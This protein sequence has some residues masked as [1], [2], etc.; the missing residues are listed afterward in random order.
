MEGAAVHLRARGH[1]REQAPRP[2]R[3]GGGRG[4]ARQGCRLPRG[5]A[6]W[7]W[8]GQALQKFAAGWARL[9]PHTRRLP[10]SPAETTK[11]LQ[12]SHSVKVTLDS[13]AARPAEEITAES[14]RQLL[15]AAAATFGAAR[16]SALFANVSPAQPWAHRRPSAS[17]GR[18]APRARTFA[19]SSWRRQPLPPP[20]TTGPPARTCLCE[21]RA[22]GGSHPAT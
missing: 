4:A 14:Q 8:S 15:S 11:R 19:R 13:C 12:A 20:K 2:A 6:L 18:R 17:W 3:A 9:K 16:D 7:L 10:S 21:G 22:G 1:L 5:N